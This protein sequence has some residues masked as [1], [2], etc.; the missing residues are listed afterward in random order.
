[1]NQIDTNRYGNYPYFIDL[2]VTPDD[3]RENQY[4][5]NIKIKKNN[6]IQLPPKIDINKI[7]L[8][9]DVN[10]LSKLETIYDEFINRNQHILSL[11]NI[12]DEILDIRDALSI[13]VC[14]LK[15]KEVN[16]TLYS[17]QL[18][19]TKYNNTD[20]CELLYSNY[21]EYLPVQLSLTTEQIKQGYKLLTQNEP[22]EYKCGCEMIHYIK[23]NQNKDI[24]NNKKNNIIKMTMYCEYHKKLKMKE[25]LIATELKIVQKELMAI[26]RETNSIDYDIEICK[27]IKIKESMKVK[28]KYPWK[29]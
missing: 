2:F 3:I 18:Q 28:S 8:M 9:L 17:E 12:I 23:N 6:N 21:Q 20:S 27:T 14:K 11:Y 29:Q 4:I 26:K 13:Q 25:K 24:Y 10:Y 7:N 22:R 19:N 16:K 15:R 1:M 5:K